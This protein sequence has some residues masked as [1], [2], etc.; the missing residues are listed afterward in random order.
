LR[1]LGN[2]PLIQ[3]T[4]EAVMKSTLQ[5]NVVLTT[6]G[7]E[8]RRIGREL[9]V[10]HVHR[11]PAELASSDTPMVPVVQ[12]ALDFW[13][14]KTGLKADVIALLQP[15][16]PFR[17]C[18]H[19]NEAVELYEGESSADSLVSV[20]KLPHSSSPESVMKLKN[21]FLYTWSDEPLPK[22]VTERHHK[23]TLYQRNGPAICFSSRVTLVK[24]NVLYGK[25]CLAYIMNE[26]SSLDID[27]E[28]DLEIAEAYLR[29]KGNSPEV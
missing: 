1:P 11:R 8:I 28:I 23:P 22:T 2:K 4:L 18:N 6:D 7:D 24:N 26:I 17:T 10:P 29:Y 15:T 5:A 12:N 20:K 16:S 27:D 13:E 19:I 3:W 25:K 9:S 21:L 14:S